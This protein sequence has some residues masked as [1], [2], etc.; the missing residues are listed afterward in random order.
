MVH[1]LSGRSASPTA[2]L[3]RGCISVLLVAVVA[4][5][6]WGR[7]T[8]DYTATTEVGATVTSLGD[9]L[10]PDADVKYRGMLIGTADAASAKLQQSGATTTLTLK[11][12]PSVATRIP[13]D[14]VARV[15]P[16]NLFGVT[17]IELRGGSTTAGVGLSDGDQIRPDTSP[18][19]RQLQEA[20]SALHRVLARVDIGALS[21]VLA[22]VD[23]GVSGRSAKTATTIERLTTMLSQLREA[24]PDLRSDLSQLDR[25]TKSLA[26]SAPRLVDAVAAAL[27]TLRTI[28][29]NRTGLVSLYTTA[30][31]ALDATTGTLRPNVTG[32]IRLI[33]NLNATVGALESTGSSIGP[34]VDTI[35]RFAVATSG[36]FTS[37]DGKVVLDAAINATPYTPYTAADCPRYGAMAGPN[38]PAGVA[39]AMSSGQGGNLGGVGSRREA[40]ILQALFGRPL[41]PIERL[42]LGPALRGHTFTVAET[43]R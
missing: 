24:V 32:A 31:G 14:V 36:I 28:S 27:P 11:L 21:R 3:V 43:G 35:R 20:M 6:L 12:D 13:R 10:G 2:L 41:T 29:A 38:C 17:A 40:D 33:T 37:P 23:D 25:S 8:G 1:D 26:V 4:T 16:T 9:G 22:T 18:Q 42:Q 39:P 5:L 30:G 19:T 15:V 7:Y 34:A